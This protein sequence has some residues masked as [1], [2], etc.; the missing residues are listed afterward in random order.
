MKK[1]LMFGLLGLF[2]LA[3]CRYAPQPIVAE[4]EYAGELHPERLMARAAQGDVLAAYILGDYYERGHG[5]C[6]Q[7]FT[8]ALF[9]YLLAD[10]SHGQ[11]EDSPALVAALN[12]CL[13]TAHLSSNASV[14][15]PTKK[16]VLDYAARIEAQF[17]RRAAYVRQIL[18]IHPCSATDKNSKSKTNP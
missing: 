10:D 6:G 12:N 5:G 7:D 13:L 2:L 18:E 16:G 8:M 17:P 9:F 15:F 3:G 14:E 11:S 1:F 4:G